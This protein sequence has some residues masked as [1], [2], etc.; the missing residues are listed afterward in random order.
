MLKHQ[1]E[2]GE[3]AETDSTRSRGRAP[4]LVGGALLVSA[5]ST[6]SVST[7]GATARP[8]GSRERPVQ[9]I[10]RRS[11]PERAKTVDGGGEGRSDAERPT[12][13]GLRTRRRPG[14]GG[15]R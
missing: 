6:A 1:A 15:A 10:R 3:A 5:E 12:G 7:E 14:R 13:P 4:A 9:P 8:R 2:A 11:R